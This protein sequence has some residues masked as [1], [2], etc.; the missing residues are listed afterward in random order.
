MK[1]IRN[2]IDNNF[3]NSKISETLILV[4]P[5]INSHYVFNGGLINVCKKTFDNIEYI[6]LMK[7]KEMKPNLEKEI[8]IGFKK[9][10]NLYVNL[11]RKIAFKKKKVIFLSYEYRDIIA[12]L[13]VRLISQKSKIYL[14]EHNT[15]PTDNAKKIKLFAFSVFNKF[16]DKIV[17]SSRVKYHMKKKY[18]KNVLCIPHPVLIDENKSRQENYI[19]SPSSSTTDEENLKLVQYF[20][21]KKEIVIKSKTFNY[22]EKKIKIFKRLE[23]YDEMIANCDAL[24]VGGGSMKYRESGP[25]Y[26]GLALNKLVLMNDCELFRELKDKGFNVITLDEYSE[27]LVPDTKKYQNFKKM[28][29]ESELK[30]RI[31][32][33]A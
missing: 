13:C 15:I 7:P 4:E 22:Y 20:S 21:G 8:D 28:H 23:D 27:Y 19:L 25:V 14:I 11:A 17:L 26:E 24:F 10:L 12:I 18:N 2:S 31:H 32:K 29:S 33:I 5:T 9:K 1:I 16:F 30:K 3:E 6:G